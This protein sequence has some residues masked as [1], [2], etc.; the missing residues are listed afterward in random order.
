MADVYV[1]IRSRTDEKRS[2]SLEEL[3]KGM[4]YVHLIPLSRKLVCYIYI[5]KSVPYIKTLLSFHYV[6]AST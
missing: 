4:W 2:A 5:Y 3:Y 1:G 6:A